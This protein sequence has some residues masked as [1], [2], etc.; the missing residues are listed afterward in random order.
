M[1]ILHAQRKVL[2]QTIDTAGRTVYIY[3]NDNASWVDNGIWYQVTSNGDL[4]NTDVLN[5]ASS[6]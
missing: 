1:E 2:R 6:L 5:I 3:G 4:S